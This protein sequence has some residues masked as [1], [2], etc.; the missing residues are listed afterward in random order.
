MRPPSTRS[1]DESGD[2]RQTASNSENGPEELC[3]P[4]RP[5]FTA[6]R[7]LARRTFAARVRRQTV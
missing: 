7:G 4:G 3:P 1:S 2:C 6:N 5:G